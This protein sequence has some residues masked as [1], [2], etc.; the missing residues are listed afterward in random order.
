MSTR[1]QL[2]LLR[3]LEQHGAIMI[4]TDDDE[5]ADTVSYEMHGEEDGNETNY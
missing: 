5:L 2:A 4:V 3:E 1:E